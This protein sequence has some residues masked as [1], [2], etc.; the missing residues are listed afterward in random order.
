MKVSC[1]IPSL[2]LLHAVLQADSPSRM[3]RQGAA[4]TYHTYLLWGYFQ[5]RMAQQR[6]SASMA[7]RTSTADSGALP[8]CSLHLQH[9]F[10]KH[11][12]GPA[13]SASQSCPIEAFSLDAS[14]R[15]VPAGGKPGEGLSDSSTG[16]SDS[17][18][19]AQPPQQG[20]LP[21]PGHSE[22]SAR[23]E[24]SQPSFAGNL[25]AAWLCESTI[26]HVFRCTSQWVLGLCLCSA[27][28]TRCLHC[29]GDACQVW[30]HF[31][32]VPEEMSTMRTLEAAAAADRHLRHVPF[33]GRVFSEDKF[34]GDGLLRKAD[35]PFNAA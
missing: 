35:V 34:G 13:D 16:G 10:C 25:S 15:V 17:N 3:N 27:G 9:T 33:L 14:F 32:S 23:R 6:E 2:T 18:S 12:T 1:H 5:R 30:R 28:L 7:L 26:L 24:A 31:E 11:G 22:S 21:S 4:R 20:T 8:A 19:A 29:A